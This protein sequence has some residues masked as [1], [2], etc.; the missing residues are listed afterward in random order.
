[1]ARGGSRGGRGRGGSRGG[2]ASKSR[3]GGAAK[4]KGKGKGSKKGGGRRG[5]DDDVED[6]AMMTQANERTTQRK[7]KRNEQV[8]LYNS[9]FCSGPCHH[10]NMSCHVSCVMYMV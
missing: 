2:G 8:L 5:D 7:P 6:L 3:G 1:M 4:G 9:S 10:H